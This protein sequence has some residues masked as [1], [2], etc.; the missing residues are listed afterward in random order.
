MD[1][2]SPSKFDD[3]RG[4]ALQAK[5]AGARDPSKADRQTVTMIQRIAAS[6]I[7]FGIAMAQPCDAAIRIEDDMGGSLGAYYIKFSNIR[8]SGQHV[9]IDGD[10]FSACTIVTGMVAHQNICIT[11]RARFGF[12]AAL[13]PNEFGMLAVN[14][15]A[16]RVLYQLY[17]TNIRTWL[18][19][20]GGLNDRTIVLDGNALAHMYPMCR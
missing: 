5:P 20:N 3:V 6:I 17:P 2:R 12:H 13:A 19:R 10:C 18:H 9:I 15:T 14:P 7:L 1:L 11:P 16:T 4:R 8:K